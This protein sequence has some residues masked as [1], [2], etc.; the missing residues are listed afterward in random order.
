MEENREELTDKQEEVLDFLKQY[1]LNHGYPP[2]VREICQGVHL[3]STSSVHSHLSSLERKGYIKRDGN[4]SR[5]IEIVSDDEFAGLTGRE[6]VNVPIIGEVA[7]GQ[8]ILANENILDYFPLLP[9]FSKAGSKMFMLKVHGESMIK[10]G[11]YDGDYILVTQQN[12][13]ENGEIVVAMIEDVDGSSATVKRYYKE[14]GRIRLQPENDTM[15]PIYP[16]NCMILGKVTGLYR[17]EI[18]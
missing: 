12:K 15:D 6:L 17:N 9:G 14:D 3:S 13:A 18:K 10:A 1:I 5:T 16:D 7:A 8:P 11:I 2:S 4:K